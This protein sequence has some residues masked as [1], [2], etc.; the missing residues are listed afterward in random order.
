M[1]REGRDYV[2]HKIETLLRAKR[3]RLKKE[4]RPVDD[5]LFGYRSEERRHRGEFGETEA[6]TEA[7][8]AS[9]LDKGIRQR[10]C[11]AGGVQDFRHDKRV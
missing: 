11:P 9:G 8:A 5:D 4:C 2:E 7:C 10:R 6:L 3:A 1:R